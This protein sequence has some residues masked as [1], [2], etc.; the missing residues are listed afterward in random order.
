MGR[1]SFCQL[2]TYLGREPQDNLVR[3]KR[4]CCP[5]KGRS[6]ELSPELDSSDFRTGV[7]EREIDSRFFGAAW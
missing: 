1:T 3:N 6:E 5:K 4:I 7:R 2:I